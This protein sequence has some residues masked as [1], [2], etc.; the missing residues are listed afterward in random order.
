MFDCLS[1]VED[2]NDRSVE[3]TKRFR[4]KP[5]NKQEQGEDQKEV[6]EEDER[7]IEDDDI[8]NSRWKINK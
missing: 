4:M 5:S 8:Q 6:E 1:W 7:D 3:F 2:Y